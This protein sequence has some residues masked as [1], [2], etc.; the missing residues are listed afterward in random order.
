M[1]VIGTNGFWDHGCWC[2]CC[3]C[4]WLSSACHYLG[5][6]EVVSCRPCISNQSSRISRK[7]D[8]D[9]CRMFSSFQQWNLHHHC[10]G[11]LYSS[12]LDLQ[13]QHA[14]SWTVLYLLVWLSAAIGWCLA[15]IA[16]WTWLLGGRGCADARDMWRH[17]IAISPNSFDCSLMTLFYVC[18]LGLLLKLASNKL[19]FLDHHL[20]NLSSSFL[21]EGFS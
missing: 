3:C 8:R 6:D 21:V 5:L 9:A 4:F 17:A 13:W 14:S 1:R 16:T 12:A 11:T 20:M 10:C 19:G 15:V 18:C 2:C 7:W